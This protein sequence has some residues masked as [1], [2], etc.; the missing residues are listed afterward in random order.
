MTLACAVDDAG[1]TRLAYGSVG[2]RPVLVVDETGRARR[3]GGAG[4]GEDAASSRR[5]SRTPARRRARCAPAPST[6]SRCCASSACGR[7]ATAIERLGGGVSDAMTTTLPH[8]GDR[9][10]ARARARGRR[11]PHAA[12]R[13]PRR[14]RP[15]RHEG[16]LPRR[17]SA[18]RAPSCVDGRSSTPAWSSPSRPTA[19]RSRPSRASPPGTGSTRSSRRSSTT[20]AVQCGFCIPGQLIAAH[21]A[22]R[23]A[24]RTR[25]VAEVEEG[26]AGNLCRCGGYEQ[27]IEAVLAAAAESGRADERPAGVGGSPARVGGLDRVTGRQAYVA[28][29]HL[30]RRAPRQARDASTA[31]GP[32]S[33]RSTRAPP[34]RSP[35]SAS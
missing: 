15:H 3:P 25:R 29:I 23:A 18:A 1:V 19:R 17:A 31:P 5:C 13:P 22:A 9:Q 10:R 26:L 28:D 6:A 33:S 12:R 7:S 8:R 27:I 34:S 21:G 32:G 14:P 2:P 4:R 35:A 11:P 16:V 24:P 30:A 20:G